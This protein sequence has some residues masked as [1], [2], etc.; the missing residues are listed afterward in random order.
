MLMLVSLTVQRPAYNRS[1]G[2][3][4]A[5]RPRVRAPSMP[6]LGGMLN[7]ATAAAI[8]FALGRALAWVWAWVL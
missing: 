8:G 2:R 4:Y 5:S 1:A 3:H 7:A 6:L